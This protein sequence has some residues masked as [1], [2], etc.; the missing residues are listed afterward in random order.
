MTVAAPTDLRTDDARAPLGVET[1]P[2]LRWRFDAH[3]PREQR[4]YRVCI[5]STADRLPDEADVWD[6]GLVESSATSV[7][8]DG[9]PLDARERYHWAVRVWDE[10][11]EPSPWSVSWWEMGMCG[12]WSAAWIATGEGADGLG[13]GET[14]PAPYFRREIDI[15][16]GVERARLYV[17]GAGYHDVRL[18]GERVG[19]SSGSRPSETSE[20][21]HENGRIGDRVLDPGASDYAER[22]RYA[23]F[24][25]TDPL[26]DG[27]NALAIA[28]GRARYADPVETVWRWHDAPWHS[29]EPH[30]IAQLELRL[31]DGTTRRIGT[32]ETWRAGEGG[33]RRDSLFEGEVY[34]ARAEPMGWTEPGFDDTGWQRATVVDG[35][36]GTLSSQA[37]QPIEV[38]RRFRPK[39]VERVDDAFVF[40]AGEM[41]VGWAEL[42][43]EGARGTAVELAYG[44][45]RRE[46]GR[47]DVRDLWAGEFPREFVDG[48]LQTDRYV[49]AGDGIETWRPRFSYRGFRYIEVRGYPGEPTCADLTIEVVHTAV[50]RT[51]SE[52]RCDDDLVERIHANSRRALVNNFHSIPTD[53]PMY[54]KNG[55]TGDA[56]VTA[57]AALYEFDAV[58]FYRKWLDDVA[59]AQL[60]SGEIPRIV[61]TSDWGYVEG[62][63]F[64]NDFEPSPVWDAAFLYVPWWLYQYA[65]DETALECHYEGMKRLLAF[66][67]ERADGNVI[68]AGHG[69]HLAPEHDRDHEFTPEGP[70]ITSTAYYAGM[71]DV[72]SEVAGVL[73][74]TDDAAA[75]ETRS[76][77][78][79][80]AFDRAFF[81]PGSGVYST[82][83]CP[84][85]R[86]A[87]NVLPLAFGLVPDEHEATVLDGLVANIRNEHDGHLDTG[88]VGTK[89]LFPTLTAY[90]HVD[91]AY[92]VATRTT[93][94]SY[95]A[96]IER[97]AT[98]LYE[99]W[100]PHS[101]S[102]DHHMYASIV[103]WFYGHLVGIAPAAPGFET[104]RVKPHPPSDLDRAAAEVETVRG[105]VAA[106]WERSSDGS[107]LSVSVPA[108][109]E[110]VVH[111]PGSDPETVGITS[112][113]ASHASAS[114]EGVRDDRP[115]YA[116]GSGEW[117]FVAAADRS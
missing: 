13:G 46:N 22:V 79:A 107:V 5:A 26:D 3:R 9:P 101:R 59:D 115:L 58:R 82:G 20:I 98:A 41:V 53:T 65:G 15:G 114:F 29:A 85:Y 8:Y 106:G 7:R 54:E 19:R 66:H 31:A 45:R 103:D 42:R 2:T 55:W 117:T 35:P 25:V 110:A 111:V 49:L 84:E 78:I 91:L 80:T 92:E 60:D 36:D 6:S 90:G 108:N 81:D 104:V 30:L 95:G 109:T 24:D 33:T 40:D 112:G 38:R 10:N 93:Y 51:T 21:D 11:G 74:H 27:T 16:R 76:A 23:T 48:D 32:D 100:E 64:E 83:E 89:H 68:R 67:R 88:V 4:A 87:S 77:K 37:V 102:R 56:L 47:V 62:G 69:D 86:Q 12:D 73:G 94:P 75:F 99:F 61:P 105:T 43:V 72:L 39:S 50:D 17:A 97:G 44:E 71:A 14:S 63:Q 1:R 52:F 18:N 57:E 34:D 116:V 113:S 96:W 28:C 70:A